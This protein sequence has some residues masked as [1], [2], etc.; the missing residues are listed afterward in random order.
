MSDHNS[1][2]GRIRRAAPRTTAPER[3]ARLRSII[4]TIPDAIITIDGR[5]TIESF[6]PAAERLFG[7]AA[8]EAIGR[9]VNILMPSPYHARHDGYLARYLA[10]GERRIIGIGRI[11]TGKRR[12]DSTFPMELAV[13]EA[14][15]DGQRLFT[16]FVRDI[17]ERQQT[18]RRLQELQTE[19][20]HVAR[21]SA[22]GQMG[23]AL[24]HELNQPLTAI[25]NY[26][27]AA[28]RLLRAQLDTVPA[29]VDEVMER[30]SAQANR[31]GQIIRR[32]RQFV[33]KRETDKQIEDLNQIV[34]EANALALVGAKEQ[35]VRVVL[36]LAPDLPPLALDK[37]QVQQ[38][39]L[40]LVRN[41]LEA[42][43]QSSD[44]QLTITTGAGEGIAQV[45]IADTGSGLAPEVAAQLFAPFVTTKPAGMGVG[46]SICRSIVEAHGGHIGADPN[47]QG[48]TIFT[49]TLPINATDETD[50]IDRVH[51]R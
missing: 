14:I 42:M 21:L 15:V 26:I 35:G 8:S 10:T 5:G 47:P 32:L 1:K 3:E 44:R 7:Y 39:V 23:S 20:L 29:R 50:A 30:A 37:I 12:D 6:S 17:T 4:E 40:N 46:L 28:R 2:S 22:M 48:G 19:L 13:G 49:F 45:S 25:V 41:A 16:G 36:R 34:E 33:E 31:A 18:Q 51:R 27:Q 24:A 43:A 9:N 38:V 11:V